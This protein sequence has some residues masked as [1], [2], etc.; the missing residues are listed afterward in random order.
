MPPDARTIWALVDE[1]AHDVPDAL[2]GVDEHGRRL[3]FGEYRD[4]SER[5]AAYLTSVG[6]TPGTR[7]AWQLPTCLEAVVLV[8]ALTRIGAVQIPVLPIYREPRA[9]LHPRPGTAV[10]VRRALVVARL[11]R[12]RGRRGP[13]RRARARLPGAHGRRR[14]PR[15]RSVGAARAA[16]RRRGGALDLLH[17]RHHRRAEGRTPHRR[18]DHRRL[19]GCGRRLRR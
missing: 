2:L 16:D 6:V 8:G 7:V 19:G 14:T 17:Q 15:R 10:G 3:T 9:A 11:R 18:V 13:R 5:C 12:R 1:R 4:Q